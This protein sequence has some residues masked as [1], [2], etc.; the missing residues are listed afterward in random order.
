[1][2]AHA[3]DNLFERNGRFYARI[4]VKGRDIRRSLR[5]SSR[6]EAERRLKKLLREAEQS[7]AEHLL[8]AAAA[9]WEDAVV[10]W[11]ARFEAGLKPRT[12]VRYKTSLRALHP[13]LS[14]KPVAAIGGEDIAAF[15]E[16]R[17]KGG[18]S[19]T[20]IR[21]DLAVANRVFHA[22]RKAKWIT[23]SPVPDEKED[24]E[25]APFL[26]KPA[27]T[28][29]I[30]RVIRAARVHKPEHSFPGPAELFAFLARVGCRQMEGATLEWPQVDLPKRQV[31]FLLTKT[32]A[33]RVVQ[34]TPRTAA[35]MARFERGKPDKEGRHP[36]FRDANGGP[37][38][39]PAQCW[40]RAMKRAGVSHFRCHDLRHTYA[41]R[42]LQAD[43]RPG[44]ADDQP[45]GIFALAQH[46]GHTST[47]TTEI[48]VRFLIR[49]TI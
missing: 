49:P 44:R 14:G 45:R 31:T 36:V 46:L 24:V 47:K 17:R 35:W 21:H 28:R 11:S 1:M 3:T 37:I 25:E 38:A 15:I 27:P 30:A 12:R 10:R 40:K 8:P 19:G 7:R 48:Y 18:A 22:A 6:A 29:H 4:Q 23:R 20:T 2:S 34:L 39:D 16:A 43:Q 41:I 9:T 42:R 26:V 5:T 13:H 33:P 32:S